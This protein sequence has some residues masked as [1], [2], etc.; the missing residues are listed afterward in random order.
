[1]AESS[2]I[3]MPKLGLTMTEGLLVS[4][5]VKAGDS[6]HAGDLLFTVETDKISTDVEARADGEILSIMVQEGNTVSVGTPVALWT[7]PSFGADAGED[8]PEAEVPAVSE[9]A[10]AVAAPPSTGIRILATPLARRRA[11]QAGIDLASI[12]GSGGRGRIKAVDISRAVEQGRTTTSAVAPAHRSR[13]PASAFERVV[14]RRLTESK[15]NIP[16][17]YVLTDVDI[18]DLLRLREQLNR[19]AT[20]VR[21]SVNHFIVAALARSVAAYPDTNAVWTSDGIDS[22]DS[23]DIGIAVD[24][25]R[26]LVVP[27]LRGAERLGLDA[28]AG[29]ATALVVK[30]RDGHL[31]AGDIEGGA[32]SVSNVGMFGATAL[33]PIINPGQSAILGV[34]APKDIFRPDERGQP[35]LARQL[36]LVLSCDHRVLDGVRAARLLDR[37]RELLESPA[38]LIRH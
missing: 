37:V 27:V 14:A 36:S 8:A 16:H 35:R 22:F 20:G 28:L 1:M 21:I 15:Q 32:F 9:I 24:S 2:P 23:V 17:F 12:A 3:L 38:R 18:T 34:G 19:D 7:G 5:N 13:R 26:G 30:A 4:W 31:E 11:R 25:E 33:V 29:Q 6:V 10:A